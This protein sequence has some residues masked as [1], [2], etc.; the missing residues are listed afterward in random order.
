M[1]D[2]SEA[3]VRN[4]ILIVEDDADLRDSLAEILTEA[5]YCVDCAINGLQALRHLQAVAAPQLILMDLWMPV[6]DGWVFRALLKQDP[7]LAQIPVVV[8]S[9]T[10][11]SDSRAASLDAV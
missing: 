7:A 2:V 3:P 10:V 6:M 4:H 9:A 1:A 8:I 11:P 5:G